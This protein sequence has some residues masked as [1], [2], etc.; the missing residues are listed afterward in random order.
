MTPPEL[1]WGSA[2]HPGRRAENKDRCPTSARVFA[3]AD[4]M[5]GHALGARCTRWRPG[6][7][8]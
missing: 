5:G 4:G 1:T 3:V 6:H 2:S 8:S 7:G